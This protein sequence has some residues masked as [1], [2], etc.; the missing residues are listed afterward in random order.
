MYFNPVTLKYQNDGLHYAV[1]GTPGTKIEP[2]AGSK[3]RHGTKIP[4]EHVT[5][6]IIV[7]VHKNVWGGMEVNPEIQIPPVK[8]SV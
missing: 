8:K 3:Y 4:A 7:G 5:V 1:P 2:I 6:V